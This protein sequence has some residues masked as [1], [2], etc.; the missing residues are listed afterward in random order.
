MI[1]ISSQLDSDYAQILTEVVWSV[2]YQRHD[3]SSVTAKSDINLH[4]ILA[5]RPKKSDIN[6]IFHQN[7]DLL[8]LLERLYTYSRFSTTGL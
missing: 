4:L 6:L 2:L 5:K 3:V 1:D 7:L 8:K